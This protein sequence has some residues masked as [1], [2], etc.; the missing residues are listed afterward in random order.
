MTTRIGRDEGLSTVRRTTIWIAGGALVAVGA[1][2]ALFGQ[3][4]AEATSGTTS[5]GG[6]FDG[7]APSTTTTRPS[8]TTTRPANGSK[9]A[10]TTTA[11]RSTTTTPTTQAPRTSRRRPSVSSG[12]S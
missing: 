7:V 5:S 1:F 4:Q 12:G 10:P 2:A 11:P 6:S 3:P 8:T 9:A